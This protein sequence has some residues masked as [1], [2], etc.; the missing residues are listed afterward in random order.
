M[1]HKRRVC[2][3]LKFCCADDISIVLLRFAQT[4][5]R[6][7]KRRALQPPTK[8]RARTQQTSSRHKLAPQRTRI[9]AAASWRMSIRAFVL[10]AALNRQ[11]CGIAAR[12]LLRFKPKLLSIH[13]LAL[14]PSRR[15]RISSATRPTIGLPPTFGAYKRKSRLSPQSRAKNRSQILLF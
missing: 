9:N 11:G 10:S 15:A 4:R 13:R 7:R 1:R 6:E 5:Q 8:K 2:C 12:R 14:T 3:F